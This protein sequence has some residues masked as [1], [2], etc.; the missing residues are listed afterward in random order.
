MMRLGVAVILWCGLWLPPLRGVL[1]ADMAT[2]MAVQLPLLAFVGVLLAPAVGR[3]EPRW[4]TEA[5]WLGIPGLVLVLFSTS[6]WML[7][8]ALDG[9]LSDWRI[10]AA[11]FLSLPLAVGLP[12]GLSWR[13]MPPVGRGFVIANVISKLGA[14]GGLFLAA[15]VRLCA[16]YRLDQQTEAGWLLVGIAVTLAVAAFLFVFCGWSWPLA[17][18][19]VRPVATTELLSTPAPSWDSLSLK[20]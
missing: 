3:Y 10:E 5:D 12:L 14:A 11:K 1:E 4:L 20:P 17:G 18:G 19:S 8:L 2:H 16:Y 6:Y 7:P 9:A 13:R 15:P